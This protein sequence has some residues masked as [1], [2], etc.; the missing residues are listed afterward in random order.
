MDEA[1][2]NAERFYGNQILQHS[3]RG[4]RWR[5][6]ARAIVNKQGKHTNEP[7]L[8]VYDQSTADDA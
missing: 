7:F 3:R 5:V 6:A 4:I 8:F 2:A 1:V